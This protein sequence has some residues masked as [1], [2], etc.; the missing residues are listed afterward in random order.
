[1]TLKNK[2]LLTISGN[3]PTNLLE[4][5]ANGEKPRTDYIE[6]SKEFG[7]DLIDYQKAEATT[8]LVGK[9][10]KKIAGNNIVLAWACFRLRKNYTTIFTDG[11]Q[12]GLPYALLLRLFA[13][14]PYHKPSHLMIVH[15]LSTKS[16]K[17]MMTLFGL[18]KHI[19]QFLVYSTRQQ[20]IICQTW[21]LP[22][23][24]VPF[25]PFMVD[26]NFF[27]PEKTEKQPELVGITD[28]GKPY[29]C[30]VGLEFRDY[31]TF[32]EAVDGLDIHIVIAAGSPWSK[33]E[34]QTKSAEVPNN[35]TVKRFTQKELCKLYQKSSF[36][37]MPLLENDFQAGI[38]A[39]LEAMAME[40][41]IICSRT[42]G[43]IDVIKEGVTG[44]YVEPH[45]PEELKKAIQTL[46]NDKELANEMGREARKI[47]DNEM[48]L[49]TYTKHLNALIQRSV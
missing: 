34:D 1:M 11:E 32:M 28:T 31:P 27:S 47:I 24:R 18:K 23:D 7:A 16:K 12:V 33:R 38:T 37:V 35:V 41:A 49:D 14:N 15:I 46:L 13:W 10:L 19:D 40:K 25:T 43:Q 30:S 45:N 29:I 5:I 36:V 4:D 44:L 17:M 9:V 48:N 22:K 20:E 8:G 42:R 26:Q 39:I 2:V 3:I 21:N 6:M